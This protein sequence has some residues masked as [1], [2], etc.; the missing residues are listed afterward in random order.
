M[1]LYRVII[2]VTDIEKAA[3]FYRMVLGIEGKRVSNGR[4]YFDCGG[5]ILAC[6]DPGADGDVA[7]VSPNPEHIYL[8][9]SNL[10]GVY[11]CVKNSEPLYI[12]EGIMKR[13]WGEESFYA[14]DPFGN[15]LCFVKDNTVFTG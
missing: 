9:V 3:D 8:S 12:E 4:H 13:P 2:P 10:E 7:A 11:D 6:F 5:T 15:P 1:K 14:K